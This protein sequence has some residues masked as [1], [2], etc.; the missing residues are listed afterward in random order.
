MGYNSIM[1]PESLS[2]MCNPNTGERL[3][4]V[5]GKNESLV[6]IESGQSFPIFNGIPS[7]ILSIP[8]SQ[9]NRFWGLAYDQLAFA[10]DTIINL[11]G[12][13]RVGTE[14][15]VR[16]EEIASM[17]IN[18]GWK[19]LEIAVGTCSNFLYLPQGADLFGVDISIKMLRR[20]QNKLSRRGC[21]AE[22]IHADAQSLPFI[23]HSFDIVYQ[24]GGL[25]F[26]DD[27]YRS[28]C[29]MV[30]VSKHGTKISIFDEVRSIERTL[31]RLA[32]KTTRSLSGAIVEDLVHLLPPG[33]QEINARILPSGEFY[34]LTF[35]KV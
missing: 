35:T 26:M 11:G 28:V 17:P 20:G 14:N 23:N 5:E 22:L 9:R 8:T 3:S 25:Q 29:E 31:K 30:R 24:M 6:G 16:R 15:I 34:S 18:P 27:P 19:V 32:Q 4:L 2:I 13:I 7:F 1:R 10:Y 12:K 21:T 33:M